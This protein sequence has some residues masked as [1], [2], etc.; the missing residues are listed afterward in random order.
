MQSQEPNAGTADS[1]KHPDSAEWMEFLYEDPSPERK[2]KLTE[3]LSR[4]P[5]CRLQVDAWRAAMASLE[6]WQAPVISKTSRSWFSSLKWAA[7]AVILLALG[8]AFGRH[9]SATAKDLAEV[10]VSMMQLADSVQEQRI[11][12]ASNH[13]A[14]MSAASAE[15]LQ[16]LSDYA[17]V[18]EDQRAADQETLALT[19]KGI[20]QRLGRLRTE[21][22][23]VALNTEHSFE[24][25]QENMTRLA[26]L[27]ASLNRNDSA[28]GPQ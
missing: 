12:M 22:E 21:L 10:K 14:V 28:T 18:Q 25:T 16:L 17:R 13:V 15:V 4:C 2:R 20:E 5:T 19:L 3:H 9:G 8:F 11:A 26:S 24:E 1:M 7:A 6:N 23:T 27:S